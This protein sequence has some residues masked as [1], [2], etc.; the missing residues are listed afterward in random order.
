MSVR[1]TKKT[2]F[3]HL[4]VCVNWVKLQWPHIQTH[5]SH[6]CL[7]LCISLFTKGFPICISSSQLLCKWWDWDSES[8]KYLRCCKQDFRNCKFK[9]RIEFSLPSISHCV[10]ISIHVWVL[11]VHTHDHISAFLNSEADTFAGDQQTI[12][13]SSNHLLPQYSAIL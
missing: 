11:Y 13:R 12:Q 5:S 10:C 6:V 4:Y 7:V 3:V 2:T 8:L 9:F 1:E